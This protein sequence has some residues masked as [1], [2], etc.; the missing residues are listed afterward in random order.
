MFSKEGLGEHSGPTGHRW[1]GNVLRYNRIAGLIAWSRPGGQGREPTIEEGRAVS[2]SLHK[3]FGYF[4]SISQQA[5]SADITKN[6][7]VGNI[8]HYLNHQY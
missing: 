6:S 2:K 8:M 4:L 1:E 7:A 3:K 5:V